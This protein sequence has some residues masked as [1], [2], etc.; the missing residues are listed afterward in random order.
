VGKKDAQNAK[1]RYEGLQQ[2]LQ[3]ANVTIMT[4]EPTT[5]TAHAQ[6]RT[7]R[8]FGGRIPD[9][10]GCVGLWSYNGPVLSGSHGREEELSLRIGHMPWPLW[11]FLRGSGGGAGC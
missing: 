5:A 8:R 1:E 3:A 7:W 4:S 11:P 9:L 2:A 6:S 10:A